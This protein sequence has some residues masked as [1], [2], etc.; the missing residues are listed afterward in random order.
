MS[1]IE[2]DIF[3]HEFG[4]GLVR[5]LATKLY[6]TP[7]AGIREAV[8]NACDAM[9]LLPNDKQRVEIYTNVLPSGD[10]VIEDW[11]TGIENLKLFKTISPGEKIVG[12]EISSSSKVNEKIIGQKG[13]GKLSFLNLSQIG[14][15]EFHSNNSKIG[16]IVTMTYDEFK[17]QYVNSDLALPH[18]G[19][20]VTIKKAIKGIPTDTILIRNLSNTFAIRIARGTKIYV[21]DTPVNHPEDFDSK[22]FPLFNISNNRTVYGNLR[23]VEK[24]KNNNI[25][26]FVK[27]V[28]VESINA[29]E[30]KVEGWVNDNYL[31]LE[32]NRDGIYEGDDNYKEFITKFYEHLE[33]CYEKRNE[34]NTEKEFKSH[35]LISRLLQTAVRSILSQRPELAKPFV[36]GKQTSDGIEGE[37]PT[38]SSMQEQNPLLNHPWIKM[39]GNIS[40]NPQDREGRP[41]GEGRTNKNTGNNNTGRV[42][43]SGIKDVLTENRRNTTSNEMSSEI[44]LKVR[45]AG[46]GLERPVVFFMQPDAIVINISRPA[47][48]ILTAK[49]KSQ[50]ELEPRAIPLLARAA[51]DMIPGSA[52][53]PHDEWIA[54]Y[55]KAMDDMMN[56]NVGQK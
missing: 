19:M 7:L 43:D 45:K 52:N 10:L 31:E 54:V 29:E 38:I 13:V 5:E 51:L 35:K 15:V 12:S 20:K 33:E 1:E 49:E 42:T 39:L 32:T 40:T 3:K 16:Y 8:S 48:E 27:N 30:F 36:M 53:L 2:V 47:S 4:K 14:E 22:Q 56:S 37:A 23:H 26:V 6:K 44:E 24:P 21:N 34:P 28:F 41:V 17:V 11:G 55:D 46:S 9:A 18:S 25:D 50:K